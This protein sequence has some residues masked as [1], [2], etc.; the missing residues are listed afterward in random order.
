MT[1]LLFFLSGDVLFVGLSAVL[2]AAIVGRFR[3]RAGRILVVIGVLLACLSAVPLPWWLYAFLLVTAVA[4]YRAPRRVVS[5]MLLGAV[6][7]AGAASELPH[8]LA[9]TVSVPARGQIVVIGDSLSAGVGTP[10]TLL[11]PDVL[12]RQPGLRVV[13]LASPGATLS[14]GRAQCGRIPPETDLVVLELGG[15]DLLAGSA[16]DDFARDLRRLLADCGALNRRVVMFELP[17]LPLQNEYGRIQRRLCAESHVALV[18]RAVIAGA[19]ASA[20]HTS[21]GLHLSAAGQAWL[22]TRMAKIL[23]SGR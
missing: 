17:L 3:A 15:N 22:G 20:G 1:P 13:N 19:V 9:P 16:R 5:A 4:W 23:R 2:A 14:S 11:W 6:T 10:Q 12:A 18:P 21:D 8:R 7:L